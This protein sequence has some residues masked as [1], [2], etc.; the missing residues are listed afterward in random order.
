M[1]VWVFEFQ[2]RAGVVGRSPPHFADA[3]RHLVHQEL[4]NPT[5]R[6]GFP[7]EPDNL[8]FAQLSRGSGL[9]ARPLLRAGLFA[10]PP[11]HPHSSTTYSPGLS[12]TISLTPSLLTYSYPRKRATSAAPPSPLSSASLSSLRL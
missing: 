8:V 9:V 4:I 2:G 3:I 5:G 6:S 12:K 1:T 10:I 11:S 7:P